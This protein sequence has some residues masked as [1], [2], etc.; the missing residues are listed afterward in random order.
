MSRPSRN[1]TALFA[2]AS[3]EARRRLDEEVG[4][5]TA[6]LEW[7]AR[8]APGAKGCVVCGSLGET[9]LNHVAGRRHGDLVVPMCVSCHRRFTARQLGYHPCRVDELRS[10]ASDAALLLRGLAQ[11]CEDRSRWHGGGH[12]E[13]AERLVAAY[14]AGSKET[15]S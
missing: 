6:W 14:A 10:P 2:K 9:E 1:L 8:G 11:L 13:L 4:E 15:E 7:S 3:K 12:A 5:A